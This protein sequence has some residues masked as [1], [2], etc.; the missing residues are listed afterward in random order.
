MNILTEMQAKLAQLRA[1]VDVLEAAQGTIRAPFRVV[2]SEGR[3][4]LSVTE[5]HGEGALHLYDL[6]SQKPLMK[7][8]TSGTLVRDHP[9]NPGGATEFRR[10]S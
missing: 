8:E 9:E 10:L 4:I 1:R 5:A 3:T 7:L 6:G 2:D